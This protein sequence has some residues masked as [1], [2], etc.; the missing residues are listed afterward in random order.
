MLVEVQCIMGD[1]EVET[2]ETEFHSNLLLC[3]GEGGRKRPP[4]GAQVT[5]LGIALASLP[6]LCPS[7]ISQVNKERDHGLPLHVDRPCVWISP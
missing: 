5:R 6:P 4:G 3:W 2:E 1:A 7:A